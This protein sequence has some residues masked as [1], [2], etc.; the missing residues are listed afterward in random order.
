MYTLIRFSLLAALMLIFAPAIEAAPKKKGKNTNS[1]LSKPAQALLKQKSFTITGNVEDTGTLRYLSPTDKFGSTKVWAIDLPEKIGNVDTSQL[2]GRKVT[3]TFTGT[4]MARPDNQLK[5]QPKAFQTVKAVDGQPLPKATGGGAAAKKKKNKKKKNEAGAKAPA[6]AAGEK[7]E[8]GLPNVL[9]LG[10][11]IS[12]GYTP[13]VSKEL[14]G[15][16]NVMRPMKS[17]KKAENCA[18]T[19]NGVKNI[20]RWIGDTKWHVIH[21]NFGLHDLKHVKADGGANSTDPNDPQQASPEQYEKNLK[22]IVAA[23][24]KSGAKLIFC[25]TTP[26][27]DKPGGPLRRADQPAIY[28]AKAAAIMKAND[29][30]INDLHA[31]VEPRM[32]ELQLPKNVHF[33]KAGSAALGKQVAARILEAL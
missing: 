15:K 3:I 2:G 9:I 6:G 28:N 20:E 18:G 5:F 8:S 27:P 4:A 19:T 10:D 1:Q 25:N 26:Y 24:K 32:K 13:F 7:G 23:L 31:F 30:P 12:I 29:I 11:S 14:A 22:Q 21:F 16:A 17:G 33:S